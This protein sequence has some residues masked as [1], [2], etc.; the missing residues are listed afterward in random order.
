[1]AKDCGSKANFGGRIT[2][3]HFIQ[4]SA[5]LGMDPA[6]GREPRKIRARLKR[7]R[8][9]CGSV[10]LEEVHPVLVGITNVKAHASINSAKA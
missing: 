9:L 8:A 7:Q 6:D 5:K 1:M 10:W 2:A 4:R 3:V